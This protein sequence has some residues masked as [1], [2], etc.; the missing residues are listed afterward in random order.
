MVQPL[1]SHD[2][3]DVSSLLSNALA[4]PGDSPNPQ[5]IIL[6]PAVS[7]SPGNPDVQSVGGV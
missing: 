3:E 4:F 6:N 1:G 7:N 5:P 2:V